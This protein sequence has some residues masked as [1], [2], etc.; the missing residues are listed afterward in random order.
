M[1]GVLREGRLEL[2]GPIFLDARMEEAWMDVE[3]VAVLDA[4]H[5]EAAQSV[6]VQERARHG[7][8]RRQSCRVTNCTKQ[9]FGKPT[10]ATAQAWHMQVKLLRRRGAPM[11]TCA[12]QMALSSTTPGNR[13][14]D[15]PTAPAAK[16]FI[17]SEC[18]RP[19]PPL[20]MGSN[21]LVREGNAP[22]LTNKRLHSNSGNAYHFRQQSMEQLQDNCPV[23]KWV[24]L[25]MAWPLLPQTR[26]I[27]PAV[28]LY[29]LAF[30]K[31]SVIHGRGT[32]PSTRTCQAWVGEGTRQAQRR[33]P[34]DDRA[35]MLKNHE[36]PGTANYATRWA[37]P[38]TTQPRPK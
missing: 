26:L 11:E 1:H 29:L 32:S 27:I 14:T 10:L 20:R 28:I 24:L 25:F 38:S 4:L 16:L 36:A 30:L 35:Q 31:T 15:K 3:H 21:K 6:L 19:V 8:G 22:T 17:K 9:Q 5:R 37:Q 33:S 18:R 2:N 12:T 23:S 34:T 7:E 13:T